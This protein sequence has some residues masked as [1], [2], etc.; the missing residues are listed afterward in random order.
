ML[1]G[2][3]CEPSVPA[4]LQARDAF[5]ASAPVRA[6]MDAPL[7]T[8]E[9]EVIVGGVGFPVY[10]LR[11]H[12][13]TGVLASFDAGG[14]SGEWPKTRALAGRKCQ[15]SIRSGRRQRSGR[16]AGLKFRRSRSARKWYVSDDV[17]CKPLAKP[18]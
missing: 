18:T 11:V 10:L 4:F 6:P 8:G 16:L 5:D 15:L 1:E 9:N 13:L 2:S 3:G 17:V 12:I 7:R 14:V